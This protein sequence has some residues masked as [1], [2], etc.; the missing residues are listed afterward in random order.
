M[1]VFNMNIFFQRT[2]VEI[3]KQPS[4]RE[5]FISLSHDIGYGWYVKKLGQKLPPLKNRR[6]SKNSQKDEDEI[7]RKLTE[8]DQYCNDWKFQIHCNKLDWVNPSS[9]NE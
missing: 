4:T 1:H 2:P 8:A 5:K 9:R 3:P 7:K 6:L